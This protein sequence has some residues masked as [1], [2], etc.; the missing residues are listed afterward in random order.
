MEVMA[1]HIRRLL[2]EAPQRPTEENY[3]TSMTLAK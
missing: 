3:A 2:A 1:E